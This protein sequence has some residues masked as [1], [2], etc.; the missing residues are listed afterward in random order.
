MEDAAAASAREARW[1]SKREHVQQ[2]DP[3]VD[4]EARV[5]QCAVQYKSQPWYN[6]WGGT[7][8]MSA[9][10]TR[11]WTEALE[12]ARQEPLTP[13]T[14]AEIETTVLFDAVD[15][16]LSG[17]VRLLTYM[18]ACSTWPCRLSGIARWQRALNVRGDRTEG[19]PKR[20]QF[21]PQFGRHAV[22]V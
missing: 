17:R 10:Q 9:D 1:R 12:F 3:F 19:K 2:V 13:I 5:G 21:L 20:R 22:S 16:D 6:I 11:A 7:P 14:V 8:S 18:L 15:Q 4:G